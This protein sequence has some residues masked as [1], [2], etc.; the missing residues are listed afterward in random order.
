MRVNIIRKRSLSRRRRG[1]IIIAID[2]N[3][4]KIVRLMFES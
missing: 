1:R 2:I 3:I 4:V